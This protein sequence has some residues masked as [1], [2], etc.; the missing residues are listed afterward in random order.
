MVVPRPA[1]GGR[2]A[3]A[4]LDIG[5]SFATCLDAPECV[6]GLRT[7]ADGSTGLPGFRRRWVVT[8]GRVLRRLWSRRLVRR[9][10]W[11]RRDG[12]IPLRAGVRRRSSGVRDRGWRHVVPHGDNRWCRGLRLTGCCVPACTRSVQHREV[13]RAQWGGI[14]DGGGR[15]VGWKI[16]VLATVFT[17]CLQS[18]RRILLLLSGSRYRRTWLPGW[19]LPDLLPLHFRTYYGNGDFKGIDRLQT[20]YQ[21]K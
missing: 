13:L 10:K 11:R 8:A 5:L 20:N 15:L 16:G 6:D 12:G 18:Q 3:A 14:S 7:S 17:W 19:R 9:P 21:A 2:L 1:L 4:L